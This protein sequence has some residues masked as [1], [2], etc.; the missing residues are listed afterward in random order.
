MQVFSSIK[1][2][3]MQLLKM[4][5][6]SDLESLSKKLHISQMA[7]YKHAKE[8][9]SRGLLEHRVQRKGVGRP[10]LIFRPSPLS[11]GVY[12]KGYASVAASALDFL[13][14]KMGNE[15]VEEFF[16]ALR[17]KSA[18]RYSQQMG[19]GTLY[20]RTKKLAS[21]R[22]AE[23]Y[24][25]EVKRLRDGGIELLEHNCPMSSLASKYPVAC[26]SERAM[27]ESLLGVKAESVC[28]SPAG[29]KACRLRLL[30]P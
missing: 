30:P 25:T 12:P 5:E 21:M 2:G 11:M 29:T 10:R 16:R 17:T 9:E 8:L 6:Q 24:M 18:G 20:I 22:N 3:M 19:D 7:V 26:E 15:G 1:Y 4:Q 28:V 27:Y 14:E 13:Q 23:G